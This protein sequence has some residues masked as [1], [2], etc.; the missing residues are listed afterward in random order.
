MI[1]LVSIVKCSCTM[2]ERSCS[3]IKIFDTAVFG[4]VCAHVSLLVELPCNE[5]AFAMVF[6]NLFV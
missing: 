3:E 5:Q 2:D 1:T 4:L 6:A